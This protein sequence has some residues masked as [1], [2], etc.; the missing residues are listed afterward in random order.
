MVRAVCLAGVMLAGAL[1][2]ATAQET[3]QQAIQ[4]MTLPRISPVT[5]DWN[6][7]R[8]ELAAN[9]TGSTPPATLLLRLNTT[10]AQSIPGVDKS[11]VPVL[12]P[13]D[14][15]ALAKDPAK[16]EATGFRQHFFL[17]GPTGYDAAYT[18]TGAAAAEIPGF[19]FKE[20]PLVLITASSVIYDLDPMVAEPAKP[21]KE[22]EAAI[23]G[24]RRRWLESYLRYSFER[25]GVT[26][27]V[28]ML[29]LDGPVRKRWV[30]CTNAANV[31]VRFVRALRL[32][33]GTPQP[34]AARV[35]TID[36][37]TAQSPDF[38]FAPSGKL[39]RNTGFKGFDGHPD[40][41]VY[42]KIRFP[43]G[44]APAYANSQSFLNWG[45]CDFTGRTNHSWRKAAPYRCRV[46]DKP[47]VFDESAAENRSYPWRDNFCEHRRYFVGQCAGGE[48]HQGQ[49]IRPGTCK[50]YNDGADRCTAFHDDVVAV[51]DGM[52]LRV[53]NRESVFLYVNVPG[54]RLRFRY[55][56]MHPKLLD[57]DRVF[58]GRVVREGEV[59][60][61]V[62]NY[63]RIPN[64]TT[65][66]LHFELQVPTRDGWVFVNPYMTLVSAYERLLG[67]RG[68]QIDNDDSRPVAEASKTETAP[69]PP[70][71]PPPPVTVAVPKSRMVMRP[72]IKPA[73]RVAHAAVPAAKGTPVIAKPEPRQAAPKTPPRRVAK[74]APPPKPAATKPA[75]SQQAAKTQEAAGAQAKAAA[76]TTPCTTRP[77]AGSGLRPCVPRY[78][79][80]GAGAK[81]GVPKL[82]QP[83]P[84]QGAGARGI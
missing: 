75:A 34:V 8:D 62:G 30:Q 41:T 55:L 47:L 4:E 23:P 63:D 25:Y 77:S 27:T 44:G 18:L 56:H 82:G 19:E 35:N 12:L 5:V 69:P 53:A 33:G 24:I 17:A 70:A 68:K 26:Y 11:A 13:V 83:V 50:L 60:G 28:S 10:V 66:H 57:D 54:E 46:N 51:R 22:L 79:K 9:T 15:D 52:L 64:G 72:A 32:V 16:A 37:P 81:P 73:P 2:G 1:V 29:C 39:I 49:D 58:S 31:L 43:I 6:A 42:A 21:S 7:V 45:N 38:T 74:Q 20:E 67:A 65:Y 14:L 3:T 48:G 36:R 84:A 76:P 61:K 78:P 59:L 80:A 40:S 71:P